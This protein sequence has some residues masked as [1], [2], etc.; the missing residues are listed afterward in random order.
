M[1]LQEGDV[2]VQRL[3]VVVVVDVGGGDAEG[4]GTGTTELLGQIVILKRKE[5]VKSYGKTREK[6]G[7]KTQSSNELAN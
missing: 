6:R 3:G 1:Q 7:T 5:A 2:V 4:L